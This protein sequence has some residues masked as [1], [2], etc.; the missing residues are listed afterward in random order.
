[1][2]KKKV[3]KK[4]EKAPGKV[5]AADSI[6]VQLDYRTIIFLKSKNALKFWLN[7]YPNARIIA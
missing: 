5:I 4:K 3:M 2:S 6:K 7:R 1:M